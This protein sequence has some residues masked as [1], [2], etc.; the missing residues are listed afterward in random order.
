MRFFAWI[1][2][3]V[4]ALPALATDFIFEDID[5]GQISLTNLRGKAV[6]IVNTASRCGF[7]SQYAGL[8]KLYENYKDN[9]LEVVAVPSGDFRQ[10]LKGE[11]M[12]KQ[13]CEINYGLTIPM[14]TINHVKGPHAHP[15][16][17]WVKKEYD[18]APSWNFNKILLDQ[19][20]RMVASF[21]S[22]AR[23]T[24]WRITKKVEALLK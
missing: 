12:V 14:T 20:G 7:T 4:T 10:E 15:F 3:M 17:K 1:L 2:V 24:G 9:G 16:Y 23:P 13:F 5:G 8:Q 18:F 11:D 19:E 22:T 21:G 6:L